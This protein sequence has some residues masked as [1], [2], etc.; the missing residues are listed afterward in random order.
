MYSIVVIPHA[1]GD[2]QSIGYNSEDKN[3]K[4]RKKY[5][6]LSGERENEE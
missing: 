5:S 4:C 3:R 2:I 1:P 6:V